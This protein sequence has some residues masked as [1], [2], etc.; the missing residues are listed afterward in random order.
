MLEQ[1]DL[2]LIGELFENAIA[3]SEVRMMKRIEESEIRMTKR[4]EESE[5]RM[6]KRIEEEI[7][8]S[9][10]RMT[11]RLE[12]RIIKSEAMV[13]EELDRVQ[14]HLEKR[15]DAVKADVEVLQTNYRIEKLR[16]DNNALLTKRVDDL[17][18]RVERLENKTA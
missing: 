8:K 12:E 10:T 11:K 13:L 7:G 17:T 2:Q 9:E 4:I 1:K 6:V 15:I 18:E 16:E 5:I 14:N 3:S